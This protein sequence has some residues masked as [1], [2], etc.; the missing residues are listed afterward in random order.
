MSQRVSE[1]EGRGEDVDVLICVVSSVLVMEWEAHPASDV[2]A[3]AV[4]AAA[5][6]AQSSPQALFMTSPAAEQRSKP[7]QTGHHSSEVLCLR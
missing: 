2:V 3:D 7:P 1:V 5:M 4:I 6:H